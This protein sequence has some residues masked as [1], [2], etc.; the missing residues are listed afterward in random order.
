MK[1]RKEH[2][3]DFGGGWPGGNVIELYGV[4]GELARFDDHS[5][6]FDFENVELTLFEL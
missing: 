5:K 2:F 3:F 4:H 1:L 6:I